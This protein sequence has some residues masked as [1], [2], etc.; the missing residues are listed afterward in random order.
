MYTEFMIDTILSNLTHHHNPI[1]PDST[2]VN[3]FAVKSLLNLRME[4]LNK[5]QRETILKGWIP[6]GD[7]TEDER[8]W[9]S[10]A[11]ALDPAILSLKLKITDYAMFYEVSSPLQYACICLIKAR[12]WNLMSLSTLPLL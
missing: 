3:H 10:Y 7:T 1:L 2:A 12:E 6:T 11:N 5:K 9:L 8:L 4:T